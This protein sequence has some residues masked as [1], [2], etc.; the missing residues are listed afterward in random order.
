M[1]IEKKWTE[2][3]GDNHVQ[4]SDKSESSDLC[5]QNAHGHKNPLPPFLISH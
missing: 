3:G 4:G 1:K 2:H 5:T